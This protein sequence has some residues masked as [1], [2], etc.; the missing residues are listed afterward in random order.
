M[1]FN[2]KWLEDTGVFQVNRLPARAAY[3][4]YDE[5]G[6]LMEISL[7]GKWKFYYASTTDEAPECFYKKDFD[8][9]NW[10]EIT[11][12]GYIQM[13]G[14][15]KYG[16]PQYVN[17]QYPWDGH[18]DLLPP[19]IPKRFNP[20]GCY[21]RNFVM[22]KEWQDGV[23][24]RF[25]GVDN[26]FALWCN[27]V[28]IGYSEDSFSPSEFDITEVVHGG[29][30]KISVEVFRFSTASWL[31]DQDFWK[32]SGI[33]RSVTLLRKKQTHLEDLW[34]KPVLSDDFTRG[35]LTLELSF[36][37]ILKGQVK[38]A[39]LGQTVE[40]DIDDE[41]ITLNLSVQNPLL[42][43]AEKPNLYSYAIEIL[44]ESGNIVEFT[45]GKFGFRRF[46][47]K[48]GLMKINGKRIVFKGV[49][50]HEWNC[51]TA[52]TITVE[53]MVEDI[54]LMKQ[55]NINAVRTSHYPNRTEWYDLCDEYGI[56]VVDEANL[57]T[58]GTWQF[59]PQEERL[60]HV[61]PNDDPKW[62]GS[63]LDRANSLLQRDK[64]HPSI[65]IWS[66]GNESFGGKGIYEMS[67][68]FRKT[69]NSRLVHYEGIVLDRRYPDTSDM[70]SQMYTPAE[71]VKKFIEEYPEKPFI[72]CEYMHMQGNSGGGT[73]LYTQMTDTIEKYQGGFIWDWVDQG[74]E[75]KNCLGEN[76]F[77]Y[78]GDFGDRPSEFEF[79]GNGLLLA[80]RTPTPKL[81]EVKGC[82]QN[83]D[84]HVDEKE[85]TIKNKSLFTDASEYRLILTLAKDG[86][87]REKR[88]LSADVL[89]DETKTIAITFKI[90][91]EPGI[92]TV[93]A[94]L[95]LKEDNLW[96]KKGH[97]VAWGQYEKNVR[98]EVA[99]SDQPVTL[100]DGNANIGV[101]GKDFSLLLTKKASCSLISYRWKGHELLEK[102]LAM[103]FWRAPT[104]NDSAA[105]MEVKHVRFK[106]AGMYPRLKEMGGTC[107]GKI[108]TLKA[109]YRL[110]DETEVSVEYRITG[111]GKVQTSL[112]WGGEQVES[113]PEFGLMMT[114]P[115]AYHKVSYL[116]NGPG[117]SYCDFLRGVTFGRYA[118]DS[119][120]GAQPY[121]LPQETG[122]RTGV[123]WAEVT[124]EEGLGLHFE[125]D[126]MMFSALPYT[127]HELENA[128]H[129]Y[130]L[131]PKVKTVIR[132][133]KG[134]LG[135]AGENTW[136]AIP[137]EEHR[138]TLS[139]GEVFNFSFRGMGE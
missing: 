56:Y 94:R 90:D 52:R 33:F 19:Q 100:V 68:L 25:D 45:K 122:A 112:K 113:V 70:E 39:T 108:A 6:Q 81:A 38:L 17:Y 126:N 54:R 49:N 53:D 59:W 115:A 73:H 14:G 77:A 65:L 36:S 107:D 51:H 57:E 2:L 1:D 15:G 118:Y 26:A 30:N 7:D 67:Q 35:K 9:T 111:D 121:F 134:Q 93:D 34:V 61:I 88:I 18:E 20:V 109:E 123:V 116:G 41:K 89:P 72:L 83:F 102:P 87:A 91:N 12:P 98:A 64:N 4:L 95:C 48:D 74:I 66:C 128:R 58:H 86:I 82:Y 133:A 24:V 3:K 136:G 46:E 99:E 106:T 60:N 23:I 105:F 130:E 104:D 131:P 28:F 13:Q 8:T 63:L 114:I 50:R 110:P 103:N 69:D 16:I 31:E 22:P 76:F 119:N 139:E 84:I 78:G 135:I 55:N 79:V 117:E 101:Y 11:V 40:K 129:Q 5:K 138:V 125:G 44:D 132:C 137:Q 43:S 85:L 21:T 10:D 96:G 32:M 124:D 75:H 120:E 29:Q 27:D 47:L 37:G 71:D 97:V 42:W 80:D 127:P 92:Y 62:Q